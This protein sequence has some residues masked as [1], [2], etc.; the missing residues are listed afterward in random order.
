MQKQDSSAAKWTCCHLN[1]A[2]RVG[3]VSLKDVSKES[4]Q[5]R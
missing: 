2:E 4:N 3:K 1:V 5:E